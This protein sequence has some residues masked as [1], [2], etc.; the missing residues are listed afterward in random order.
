M[1]VKTPVSSRRRLVAALL[2][3]SLL[4]TACAAG[5][6]RVP[7]NPAALAAN[8]Q[9][10]AN[11]DSLQTSD[12]VLDMETLNVSDG[13]VSTLRQAIDGDR[14]VLLWFYSPH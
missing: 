3:V 7:D 5:G 10:L 13:S 9:A 14:P 11:I 6:S 1:E 4:A 8:E 12:N 2:G